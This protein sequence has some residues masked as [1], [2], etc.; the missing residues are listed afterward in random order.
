MDAGQNNNLK[1]QLRDRPDMTASYVTD[2][3]AENEL[4]SVTQALNQVLRA[5]N[6][7]ALARGAGLRRT[8]WQ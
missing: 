5:Q 4:E 1:E 7:H 6:V 8:G 3:F 2:A